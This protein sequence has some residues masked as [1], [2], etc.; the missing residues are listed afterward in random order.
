MP[1]V[2]EDNVLPEE[3]PSEIL[4]IVAVVIFFGCVTIV[5]LFFMIFT[6]WFLKS[7]SSSGVES[8]L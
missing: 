1:E 6:I 5:V 3:D 4:T 7:F 2:Q 8:E